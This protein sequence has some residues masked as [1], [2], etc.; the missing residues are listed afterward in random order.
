MNSKNKEKVMEDEKMGDIQWN[1]QLER[2]ISEEGER[3]L[4]FSWLHNQS[5]KRYSGLN[6]YITLPTIVMSTLA[7]T[8]SI[9]SQT[10]F[11]NNADM[12]SYVV[13]A[14]SISVGVLN[15]ISSFFGWAKRSEGHRISALTYSKIHRFILIE[16]SL[17]RKER[18]LA[19]DM[20]KSVRDQ[21][22]RLEETS[23]A[24]PDVIIDRFNYKFGNSTPN[25]SKPEITNGLDP[26]SVFVENGD[27]GNIGSQ[28]IIPKIVM[29]SRS[30]PPSSK[31]SSGDHTPD[32]LQMLSLARPLTEFAS[33]NNRT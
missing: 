32:N 3:A 26:I 12:S 15:T 30:G 25:V 16:L 8:A 29:T 5:Q 24:I 13:G 9:G 22:D 33:D 11:Q 10:L 2:I 20:L 23:P 1:S 17:P 18:M 6:T 27:T 28:L 4:C 19:K 14:I 21:L 31:T 7:G